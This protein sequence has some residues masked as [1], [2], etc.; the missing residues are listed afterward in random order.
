LFYL[1]DPQE[2]CRPNWYPA[3]LFDVTEAEIPND[4]CFGF[5]P[6]ARIDDLSAIWGYEELVK[7]EDHFNGIA[8][9]EAP[10]L[11]LFFIARE[12]TRGSA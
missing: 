3:E 1:V 4:W 11:N 9:R 12:K 7:N 10:H 2:N 5:F 6:Y 8:E